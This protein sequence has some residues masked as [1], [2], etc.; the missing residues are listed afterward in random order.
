MIKITEQTLSQRKYTD[1][2][3][4]YEKKHI[5]NHLENSN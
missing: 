3:L 5:I 4:A 2:K 1:V